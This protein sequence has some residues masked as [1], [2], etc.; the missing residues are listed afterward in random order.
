MNNNEALRCL[1]CKKPKCSLQ[2]CPVHTPVPECMALYRAERL[3]EAGALL[4]QN[5]PLS[6]ISSRVCDWRQ[7]CFGN[8]VLNVKKIPVRWYE[9]E[10]EIS[11][12]YLFQYNLTRKSEELKGKRIALVGT[13]PVGMAAAVWLYQAGADITLF[14]ANRRLGGVLR[15]GIPGFRLDKKYV[16]VFETM[17]F[18]A[19]ITFRGGVKVGR[20]M[21]LMEL[22]REYDA[23]LIGA[24]AEKSASPR[25]PGDERA[26]Q[27]LSFLKNPWGFQIGPKVIV[28]GGGNV[29]MDTCRTARQMGYE[30]WVYYR[31]TFENMPA[32][33]V[34]VEAAQF[35]GVQFKLFEAPVEVREDG[36]VFRDCENET[37]PETG[38]VVTRILEGTDHFVPCDT[39]I[40][41][42]GERPDYEMLEGTPVARGEK[43]EPIW[44]E[45]QQLEGLPNVWVAGDF[46]LG[47]TTV[48]QAVASAKKA[49]QNL[50]ET[51]GPQSL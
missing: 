48:V 42:I 8:C 41:A 11:D 45:G 4:F 6:A 33:P 44:N 25:I 16:D 29:A 3:D 26:L 22:S 15:Y 9:I 10:Q 7:F 37:D 32:N 30:T 13:G 43:G 5:N 50:I 2:G 21:E 19:G 28:I 39:L 46:C 35:E 12:R 24:G 36:V 18:L 51:L 20:D 17:F 31:K 1:L 47:A 49:V 34:E 23:V 40:S 14:D 27:A 38:K